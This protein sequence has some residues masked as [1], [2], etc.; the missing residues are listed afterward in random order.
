M[1]KHT[2]ANLAEGLGQISRSPAERSFLHTGGVF[3]RCSGP[4]GI[5]L[6][7]GSDQASALRPWIQTFLGRLGLRLG[8]AETAPRLPSGTPFAVCSFYL[9]RR[10]LRRSHPQTQENP[11]GKVFKQR[12]EDGAFAGP[13]Y[14]K[15]RPRPEHQTPEANALI[16]PERGERIS[17]WGPN[18]HNHLVGSIL[19]QMRV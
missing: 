14:L 7:Q 12:G 5:W 6:V 17:G 11:Q 19:T 3:N 8:S 16:V 1:C 2:H 15:L 9:I 10:H 13:S 4:P 18:Q